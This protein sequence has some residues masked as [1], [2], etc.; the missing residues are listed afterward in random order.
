MVLN[1]N[2]MPQK[3]SKTSAKTSKVAA[4]AERDF[5]IE[6]LFGSK[7]RVRLLNLFLEY[8][9]RP[10]YVREITRKI[11]A[12]LN[13]VRRELQNL[14]GLGILEEVEGK[15]IQTENDKTPSGRSEKKKY[16]RARKDCPFFDEIRGIMKK[17]AILMNKSLVNELQKR[18]ELD[19]LI[20]TGRFI[21]NSDVA[22]DLLIVGTIE[23]ESIDAAIA[24][25]EQLLAR[26]VNY[27][28]MPRD[29]FSYRFDVKDRFL[30]SLLETDKVVLINEVS[31]KI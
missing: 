20:L 12:Q 23:E 19:L 30:M 14:I 17:S 7:T 26:E 13:S 1:T 24:D 11:G 22:S 16:Y 10:F 21:D 29:E 4:S 28:F 27:T 6:Q 31:Q 3:K 25:F 5:N 15:I 2:S 9:E 8:P 18:G